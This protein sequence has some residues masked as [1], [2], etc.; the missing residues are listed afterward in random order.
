VNLF[1]L[2]RGDLLSEFMSE[3]AIAWAAFAG[4]GIFFLYILLKRYGII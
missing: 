3:N 1:V 2:A 4:I